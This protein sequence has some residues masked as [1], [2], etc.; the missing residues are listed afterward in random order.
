[1]MTPELKSSIVRLATESNVKYKNLNIRRLI[2]NMDKNFREITKTYND[3]SDIASREDDLIL[4]I[5]WILDNY[6][7]IE[8]EYS[9]LKVSS[10]KKDKLIL[11]I[12]TN[13]IFKGYPQI[14]HI[15]T[16]LIENTKGNFDE[17]TIIDT[18][19]TYQNIKVLS[20]AE[21]WIFST[22][23]IFAI[24]DKINEVSTEILKAQENKLKV[25]S[26]HSEDP[27]TVLNNLKKEFEYNPTLSPIYIEALY[28]N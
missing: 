10:T 25:T 8:E 6:Y 17:N 28:K 19:K 23:L 26:M 11:G 4:G 20:I 27:E 2:S 1:M 12:L 9:K 18:L 5:S 24:M 7:K 3:L 14:Y 15:A 21:I 13:T 22:M 16:D